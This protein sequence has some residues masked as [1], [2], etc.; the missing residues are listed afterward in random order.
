MLACRIRANLLRIFQYLHAYRELQSWA[1][2][3]SH[4]TKREITEKKHDLT[5]FSCPPRGR[6]LNV[7]RAAPSKPMEHMKY[8]K[9]TV[10]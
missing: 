4:G 2:N 10:Q 1:K 5:N 7:F 3:V 9:G 8:T 6:S